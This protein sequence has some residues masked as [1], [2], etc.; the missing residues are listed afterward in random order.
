[1]CSIFTFHICLN[2]TPISFIT[3]SIK[4]CLIYTGGDPLI[5]SEFGQGDGPTFLNYLNC[6]GESK[7][8]VDCTPLFFLSPCANQDIA[9]R[10]NGKILSEVTIM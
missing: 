3:S 1:M 6:N 5:D 7:R 9:V 4:C 2:I 8:L 10:C